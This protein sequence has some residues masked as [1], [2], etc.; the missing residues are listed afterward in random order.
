[1]PRLTYRWFARI[2]EQRCGAFV[3]A[4]N[5][6]GMHFTYV[7]IFPRKESAGKAELMANANPRSAMR[8]RGHGP[9]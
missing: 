7:G 3:A 4:A 6:E 2:A 8:I 5:R 1:M 9:E